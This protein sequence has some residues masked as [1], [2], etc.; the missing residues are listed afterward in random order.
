MKWAGIL[1]FSLGDV[2]GDVT[3]T[4]FGIVYDFHDIKLPVATIVVRF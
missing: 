4:D 3:V 2:T 1:V